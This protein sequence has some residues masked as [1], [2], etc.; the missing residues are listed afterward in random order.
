[1]KIYTDKQKLRE[2]NRE[3]DKSTVTHGDSNTPFLVID[4]SRQKI[5]KVL[6]T[7]TT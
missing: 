4:T 2:L 3:I 5:S 7:W 1:M 6:K